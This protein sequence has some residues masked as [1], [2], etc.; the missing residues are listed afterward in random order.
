MVGY[1]A[2]CLLFFDCL[3]RVRSCS[4]DEVFVASKGPPG[5]AENDTE[6]DAGDEPVDAASMG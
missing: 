1:F 6:V 5:E 3:C 4:G 2:G